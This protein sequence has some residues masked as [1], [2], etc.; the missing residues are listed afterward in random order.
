MNG[1]VMQRG[2][3]IKCNN[4]DFVGDVVLFVKDRRRPTGFVKMCKLCKSKRNKEYRNKYKE[5]IKIRRKNNYDNTKKPIS[6]EIYVATMYDN[7]ILWRATY[8][9]QGIL[10]RSK[11]NGTFVDKDYF[12]VLN[13]KGMLEDN[14]NCSCCGVK[15]QYVTNLNNIKAPNVPSIDRIDNNKGYTSRNTALICWKC[16]DL[17]GNSD[18]DDLR[19]VISWLE[20]LEN[21]R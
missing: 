4:C 18:I 7:P 5:E 21:C 16:N 20:K 13:I 14:K 11:K 3:K 8:L 15:F 9:R 19:A 1:F 17:K 10:Q 6:H 12:S 2:N